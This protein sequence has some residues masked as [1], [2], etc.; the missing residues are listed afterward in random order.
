MEIIIIIL[1]Y[2]DVCE[3]IRR[4]KIRIQNNAKYYIEWVSECEGEKFFVSEKRK[5][6]KIINR[7][8]DLWQHI[9]FYFCLIVYRM[10][11]SN[12]WLSLFANSLR[13]LLRRKRKWRRKRKK[14]TRHDM[15]NS[16]KRQKG[17]FSFAEDY[18][19]G[20]R[21]IIKKSFIVKF[22][23]NFTIFFFQLSLNVCWNF[24]IIANLSLFF[25]H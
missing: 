20:H 24:S 3:V 19:R 9:H 16:M 13:S 7:R 18:K 25:Y 21:L 4:R 1:V 8:M 23:R 22:M 10:S 17:K 14:S 11:D 5:S 6:Q 12:L 15:K 2:G